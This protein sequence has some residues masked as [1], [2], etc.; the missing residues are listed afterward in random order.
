MSSLGS[1]TG[2]PSYQMNGGLSEVTTEPTNA[3]GLTSVSAGHLS[4]ERPRNN[5]EDLPQAINPPSS[6]SATTPRKHVKTTTT[7]AMRR[8]SSAEKPKSPPSVAPPFIPTRETISNDKAVE[9][10]RAGVH[11]VLDILSS[12]CRMLKAP[13]AFLIFLWFLAIAVNTLKPSFRNAFGPACFIPGIS[14]TS[15]CRYLEPSKGNPQRAD[16]PKLIDVQCETFDHVLSEGV[17]GSVLALEIKD[18]EM[19]TSSLVILIRTSDLKDRDHLANKLEELVQRARKTAIGLQ[20]LNAK[21]GGAVDRCVWFFSFFGWGLHL[22]RK[23]E[24]SL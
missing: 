14:S 11:F 23:P 7:N 19:A 22:I 15:F 16:Y 12:A 5:G 21:V 17:S 10:L 18:A 20:R 3:S 6:V 8:A 4:F 2:P 24:S 1:A 9:A 13:L